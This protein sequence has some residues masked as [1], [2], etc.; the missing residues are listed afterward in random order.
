MPTPTVYIAIP[1]MNERDYLFR[2]LDCIARQR[3]E[4]PIKVFICVNQPETWWEDKEKSIVCENN[5]QTME[6]LN[7]YAGLS[8]QCIDRSS[9]GNGWMQGKSGVGHAR[10]ELVQAIISISSDDDIFISMDADTLFESDYCQSVVDN[11]RKHPSAVGMAVP[12]YHKKSTSESETRAMLRYEIYMRNYNL[13]L[14]RIGSPYA[15]TALGSAIACRMKAYKAVSGFD[16]RRSGEDFYFLQKLCKHGHILRHNTS[17]VYP[18]T[19]F[20]DRVPFGTGPAIYKGC[21]GDWISYPVFHYSGFEIIKQV[22]NQIER[23]FYEDYDNEFLCFLNTAFSS[24]NI[25]EPLRKNYKTISLFTK[26]FH[27]KADGLRIFQFLRQHQ[28]QLD[29]NDEQCLMENLSYAYSNQYVNLFPP[30][31]EFFSFAKSSTEQL[32]HLRNFLMEQEMGYQRQMDERT[33]KK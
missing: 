31:K 22:Y 10:K 21:Q 24:D 29:K 5:R 13:H 32:D 30:N 28:R 6:M 26:A 25:W 23:L 8:I 2:T 33:N 9:R 16:A 1:A 7:G 19:R 11:F 20:S 4:Y 12:Y 14:L 18:A 17:K 15:Y 3:C 27:T